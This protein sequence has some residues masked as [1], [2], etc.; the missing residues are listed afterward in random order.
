MM[1]YSGKGAGNKNKDKKNKHENLVATKPDMT[2]GGV[3]TTR[4][5]P[6]YLNGSNKST[7]LAV[8]A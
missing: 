8:E 4:T 5:H 1:H 6:C 7:A 3:A 2:T